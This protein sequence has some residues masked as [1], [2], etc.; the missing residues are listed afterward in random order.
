MFNLEIII[1]EKNYNPSFL[2]TILQYPTKVHLL[3]AFSVEVYSLDKDLNPNSVQKV[4]L[5]DVKADGFTVEDFKILGNL[6]F[7]QL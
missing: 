3:V 1:C 2:N 4:S 5:L 7:N 6:N